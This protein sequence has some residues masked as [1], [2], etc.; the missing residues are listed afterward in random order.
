MKHSNGKCFNTVRN[1][2]DNKDLS[3]DAFATHI[4]KENKKNIDFTGF[5]PLLNSIV[6]VINHYE[7]IKKA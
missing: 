4:V 6:E 5:K 3:K 2:N 1:R 7:S